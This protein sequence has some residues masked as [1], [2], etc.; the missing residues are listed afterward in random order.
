MSWWRRGSTGRGVPYVRRRRF[1]GVNPH[2]VAAFEAF[3][4]T[5][6]RVAKTLTAWSPEEAKEHAAAVQPALD[7]AFDELGAAREKMEAAFPEG[8]GND[9]SEEAGTGAAPLS[10]RVATPDRFCPYPAPSRGPINRPPSGR[11][12]PAGRPSDL[13]PMNSGAAE[14]AAPELPRCA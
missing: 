4:E 5:M 9:A 13:P 6:E 2:L 14:G 10:F 11:P 3:L 1:D 7:R 8:L 12:S